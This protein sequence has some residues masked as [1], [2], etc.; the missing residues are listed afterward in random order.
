MAVVQ[1]AR[2]LIAALGAALFAAL[3]GAQS[4]APVLFQV[5][6]GEKHGAINRSGELVIP[7]EYDE[8]VV[9][10]EGIAR[11]RKG[12][13]YAYL[14]AKGQRLLGPMDGG[15]EHFSQGLLAALGPSA[16][17]KTR[18]GYLDR[19]GNWAIAPQFAAAEAFSNDRAVVGQQ[20][21]WG[22]MKYGYVDLKGA[23]VVAPQYDKA[24]PFDRVA[25]VEQE[26]RPKLIDGQGRD[27]TPQGVDGFGVPSEGLT[28]V[29][30]AKL[31]GFADESGRLVVE[32]RFTSAQ[33]FK[34]GLAR[35]WQDG[36]YG[37]VD[38]KG[39]LVVA[40]Q[41][42][43]ASDFSEGLSAVRVDG[44]YGFIDATGKLVIAPRFEQVRAFS[45]G[46][47]AVREDKLWGYVDK[48][49]AWKLTPRYQFANPF[50]GGL[51]FA[52]LPRERGGWIDADGRVV[53]KRD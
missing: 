50:G 17:G 51:A 26:R 24:G 18:W 48:T 6:A 23:V 43:S 8:A 41:F 11:V 45:D 35:V 28:I 4:G 33:D 40:P 22:R 10:R 16:D 14:D 13:R 34:G 7:I 19:S 47:A 5:S 32:P 46:L 21:E 29:R 37:F 1:P 20:D 31:V 9:T 30:K 39:T 44:R 3:A 15:G 25:R 42:E 27:V 38:R 52:G 36:K 12:S 53:W 2:R 49:G